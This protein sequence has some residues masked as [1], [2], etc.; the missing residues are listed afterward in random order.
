VSTEARSSAAAAHTADEALDVGA[1]GAA[2]VAAG[3]GVGDGLGG[4]VLLELQ[5]ATSSPAA[6]LAAMIVHLEDPVAIVAPPPA[7][8]GLTP[9][10]VALHGR[11]HITLPGVN[12]I[13]GRMPGPAR[14]EGRRPGH[15]W[16]SGNLQFSYS[17]RPADSQVRR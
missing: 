2:E 6:A 17:Y 8:T 1:A 11:Q 7:S 5:A 4:G 12:A 3:V 10:S 9:R 16:C 15:G 14:T 13:A